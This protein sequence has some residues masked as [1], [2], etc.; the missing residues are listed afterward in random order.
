MGSVQF[1]VGFGKSLVAAGLQLKLCGKQ[2]EV[3]VRAIPCIEL[4]DER[5]ELGRRNI[6]R[7]DLRQSLNLELLV[8]VKK[9]QKNRFLALEV[10]VERSLR[11]TCAFRYEIHRRSLVSAACK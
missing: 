7:K 2:T 4:A 10:R 1:G 9:L 3:K 6:L 11:K 5:Q 8:C